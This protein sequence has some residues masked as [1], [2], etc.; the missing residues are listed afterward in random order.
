MDGSFSHPEGRC[1]LVIS[2]S[3]FQCL[4]SETIPTEVQPTLRPPLVYLPDV[5]LPQGFIIRIG[6][7]LLTLFL[8]V[9]LNVLK[10]SERYTCTVG[11]RKQDC[12]CVDD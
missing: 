1:R 6:G 8:N 4:N 7:P 12:N 11:V 10:I 3:N 5:C 2:A 9:A